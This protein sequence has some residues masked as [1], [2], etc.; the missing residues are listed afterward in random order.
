[1]TA[2]KLIDAH[3]FEL[4]IMEAGE[5]NIC[6]DCAMAIVDKIAEAESVRFPM[7]VPDPETGLVPCGQG[8]KAEYYSAHLYNDGYLYVMCKCFTRSAARYGKKSC[9]RLWN[10]AMG[11]KGVEE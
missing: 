9:A 10:A 7:S 4:S 8:H 6:D 11:Y 3:K 5:D 2:I 1:M